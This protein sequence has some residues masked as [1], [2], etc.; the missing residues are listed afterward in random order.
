MTNTGY[1]RFDTAIGPCGIAWGEGGVTG[2]W[3]SGE[4]RHP[5]RASPPPPQV[6]DAIDG[7]TALL[8]GAHRDLSRIVLDMEGVDDFLLRVYEVAR[9]IPPGRTLTY[10]EVARRAGQPGA[11]QAVGV[12]M[13]RNRW[14]VIVPCHRVLA[15]DGSLGGFSAPGGVAVKRRMLEIE[16]APE[17]GGPMLFADERLASPAA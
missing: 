13:A 7:I 5:R 10:G 2:V 16:G 12:A 4:E 17:A 1:A 3:L 6:R 8:A 11:A 14:P 15:A 9:A